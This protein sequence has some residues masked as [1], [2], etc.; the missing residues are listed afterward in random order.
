MTH[1]ARVWSHKPKGSAGALLQ[2]ALTPPIT[3]PQKTKHPPIHQCTELQ[4]ARHH[5]PG[6]SAE[7]FWK[8]WE[9]HPD[10]QM[11]AKLQ[12]QHF[13]LAE[14]IL[15]SLPATDFKRG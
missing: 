6:Q 5:L 11:L 10:M 7:G 12:G 14:L 15:E 2:S 3:S 4:K 9:D 1:L 8:I 13:Q